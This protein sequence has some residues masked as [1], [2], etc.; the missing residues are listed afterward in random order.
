MFFMLKG[1][2]LYIAKNLFQ[3]L[4]VKKRVVR[5]VM[6]LMRANPLLGPSDGPSNGF[7]PI[8][9]IKSECDIKKQVHW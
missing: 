4:G 9:V 5:D 6:I 2:T 3:R 1:P 8:K 7:A